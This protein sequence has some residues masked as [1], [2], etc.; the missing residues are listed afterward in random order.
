MLSIRLAVAILLVIVITS[1]PGALFTM[2]F[3]KSEDIAESVVTALL[4]V[5][6]LEQE[7]AGLYVMCQYAS[8]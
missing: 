3:A 1:R 7:V 4:L 6:A 8:Q 2:F 5:A